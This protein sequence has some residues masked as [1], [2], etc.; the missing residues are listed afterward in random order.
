MEINN[1][2]IL[3]KN[4]FSKKE[5]KFILLPIFIIVFCAMF[6]LNKGLTTGLVFFFF[7]LS[8]T[9]WVI[10]KTSIKSRE[11]YWLL[12]IGFLIH[13]AAVLFIYVGFRP[14]GGGADYELYDE[15]A[16]KIFYRFWDGNFSLSGLFLG[17]GFSLMIGIIYI[18]IMPEM[19]VGQ[20]FILWFFILSLIFAYLII[21]EI[22][23]S[24]KIAFISGLAVIFYPS[25]LYFGSLLLKDTAV[26]PLVLLGLLAAV[27][28]LKNFSWPKFLLFFIAL[29]A[30]AQLRF[31]IGYA[32]LF[33]FIFS[34]FLASSLA[35]KKRIIYGLI[36]I[37]LLGFS[38]Q[39]LGSGYYG[40]KNF[41]GFLNF[42][43]ISFFREVVY[44][45]T[46]K[47]ASNQVI[48]PNSVPSQVPAS[49]PAYAPTPAP[50]DT[51]GQEIP[52]GRGSS[53]TIETGFNE[54]VFHF[55]KN[56]SMS[57]AFAFLGPFPWQFRYQ[58]HIVSLIET[59]P[60]YLLLIFFVFRLL[61]LIRE[62]RLLVFFK[63]YKF[64][65][66]LLFF[67]IIS[68]GALSLFINNYG[69]IARIRIPVFISLLSIIFL[70]LSNDIEKIFD[71]LY[72]KCRFLA[73][74]SVNLTKLRK[75][76]IQNR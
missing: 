27:K 24:K 64:C 32:M 42:Q 58:R 19:I 21:I 67:G 33:G 72:E 13:L 31:Y 11:L 34:W 66:P 37:I 7:L 69:I 10:S 63:N 74:R 41:R 22:G 65:A 52:G 43:R 9:F 15:V 54:G 59:I 8:V 4:I 55:L 47:P 49:I 73:Q 26:V 17:H 75:F 57:F 48:A 61:K 18:F 56:Y 5:A 1:T 50:A 28:M 25:Y 3:I 60:W 2:A 12:T 76:F 14:V 20:L 35:F 6:F 44:A 16:K 38:P 46:P 53:F 51:Y 40:F 70:I 45:P 62:K 71:F 39:L 30:L 36:I 68:I 29:T 23:G